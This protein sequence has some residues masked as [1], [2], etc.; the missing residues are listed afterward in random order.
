MLSYHSDMD[1]H[2][3]PFELGLDRLVD[4]DM[5][6]DY[7]G[8]KALARI[9]REG[10]SRLQ[11]GLE[12]DGEPLPGPNTRFW[13]VSRSGQAIGKVTSAIHSPRL[14]ANIALAMLACEHSAGGTRVEVETPTG[15]RNAEIVPRPFY[16]P[17]KN[18]AKG[19]T[20]ATAGR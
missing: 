1:I 19:Q 12:I 15:R 11:V 17:R 6:A 10:V 13:P 5:E 9:A 8:K 14:E 7:V 4:L 16:D 2:T 20:S 3:N 18:L